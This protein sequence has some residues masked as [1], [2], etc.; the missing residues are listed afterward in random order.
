MNYSEMM[1]AGPDIR[2]RTFETPAFAHCAAWEEEQ[3]WKRIRAA[4]A[5]AERNRRV[6]RR[7]P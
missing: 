7:T 5:K 2:G 3:R 6:T 4:L 1:F